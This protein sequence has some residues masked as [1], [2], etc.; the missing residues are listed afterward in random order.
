MVLPAIGI[1]TVEAPIATPAPPPSESIVAV[2]GS[3]GSSDSGDNTAI[4]NAYGVN[5]PA[6]IANRAAWNDL[7]A[8]LG[9]AYRA[10]QDL[11]ASADVPIAFIRTP[12]YSAR[13]ATVSPTDAEVAAAITA[14]GTVPTVLSI[15]PRFVLMP[16]LTWARDTT[17][18]N[19]GGQQLGD[20]VSAAGTQSP[21][22][23]ALDPV[24]DTL[25][26]DAFVSAP[27]A[28][29]GQ[30]NTVDN[31]IAWA[32]ANRGSHSRF[33]QIAPRQLINAVD[34]D[35]SGAVLGA[36]I[37]VE[38]ER[39]VGATMQYAPI[40]TS[41]G[42]PHPV[43]SNSFGQI[44]TDDAARL[45]ANALMAVIRHQGLHAW[46]ST[47]GVSAATSPYRFISVRRTADEIARTMRTL[48]I[49]ALTIPIGEDF[50]SFV[51]SHSNAYMRSLEA[52]GSIAG[53]SVTRDN[54][55]NTPAALAAG[56]THFIVTFTPVYAARTLSFRIELTA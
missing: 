23:T 12:D 30:A 43:L 3:L 49:A 21:A 34:E 38:S 51:E 10:I 20:P 41:G 4:Q 52:E 15:D 19:T 54:E 45:S 37:R 6:L 5:T 32:Q 31:F 46:G 26:A 13:G 39:G 50:F 36:R 35:L 8:N 7:G 42:V 29:D 16:N 24:L 27:P 56:Q 44:L 47:F 53:G 9:S 11:Y 28:A 22:L 48:N 55:R 25:A 17:S 14:L 2:I 1:R 18:G 40:T 33:V